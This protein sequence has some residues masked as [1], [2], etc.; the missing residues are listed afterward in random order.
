MQNVEVTT[1]LH[2]EALLE[3]VVP[4]DCNTRKSVRAQTNDN[5]FSG[6]ARCLVSRAGVGNNNDPI[7]PY[8]TSVVDAKS[9]AFSP[10]AFNDRVDHDEVF[11]LWSC[12]LGL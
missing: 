5:A 2:D 8:H 1:K 4:V 11:D 10:E 6:K 12:Q 7:R 9:V 3:V